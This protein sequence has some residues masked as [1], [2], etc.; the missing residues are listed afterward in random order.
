VALLV[1]K[2]TLPLGGAVFV[3]VVSVI[4]A[5]LTVV[6]SHELHFDLNYSDAFGSNMHC[7]LVKRGAL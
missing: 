1:A 6:V 7:H 4:S 5:A 3:A 2:A